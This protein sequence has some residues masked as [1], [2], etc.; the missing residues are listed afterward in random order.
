M[1]KL[2]LASLSV[3]AASIQTFTA[4]AQSCTPISTVPTSIN[5]PGHYCLTQNLR[6]EGSV[7]VPYVNDYAIRIFSDDVTLN[8]NGYVLQGGVNASINPFSVAVNTSSRKNTVIRNGVIRNFGAAIVLHSGLTGTGSIVE[9]MTVEGSILNGIWVTG[10]NAIVRDNRV[11]NMSAANTTHWVQGIT[12]DGANARVTNNIVSNLVCGPSPG[13]A[14]GIVIN[15]P[16][17]TVKDNTVANLSG[18]FVSGIGIGQTSSGSFIQ[19]NVIVSAVTP[20]N[21]IS[22]FVGA[23]NLAVEGNTVTGF[24]TGLHLS[25]GASNKYKNNTVNLATAPYSGGVNIGGNF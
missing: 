16:S 21:G 12:V 17:A 23:N 15:S 18:G 1:R 13:M 2:L 24:T 14:T 3:V 4:S 8:F 9:K 7:P 25:S 19:D 6:Y 20:G 11:L 22:A 5:S 10:L